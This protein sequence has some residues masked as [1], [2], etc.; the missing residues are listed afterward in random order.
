MNKLHGRRIDAVATLAC[1]GALIFW[2]TGPNFIKFLTGHLDLWTQNVLRYSAACIFWLPF[3]L[4]S[5]RNRGIDGRI[6]RKALL[7]GVANL[8]M[9]SLWAGAFYY[10]NPAFMNLLVKSS[11]IWIV[12][13]SLIFFSDERA[14]A[15]SGRFWCGA[16]LSV[17]GVAGVMVFKEDFAAA[18]TVTGIVIALAAAFMWGVYTICIKI[19]FKDTDSRVGFSVISI[20]MVVGLGVLA[21]V[22]GKPGDCLKMGAWPWACVVISGVTSIGLSHVLYYTTIR[23]IGATIPSLVLLSTPFVVLAISSIA[24][25]ETLNR[26]QWLFGIVLLGGSALA[27]WAQEHLK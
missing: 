20:Y 17:I 10:I 24:F 1:I 9:Q 11:V 25:G 12:G 15:K 3:L 22:F 21:A 2:S 18:R 7:P 6:W 14:L 13:F 27:I 16:V 5:L 23:R 19:A 4:L 26:F 8:V